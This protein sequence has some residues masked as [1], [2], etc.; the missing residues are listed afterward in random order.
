MCKVQKAESIIKGH[1]L[2]WSFQRL[3]GLKF[4]KF[5]Q[6]HYS[7]AWELPHKTPAF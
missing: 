6:G 5:P 3:E 2:Y 1:V 7:I 4:G